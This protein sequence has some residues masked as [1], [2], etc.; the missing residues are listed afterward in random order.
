MPTTTL[1]VY[2]WD[3][4]DEGIETCLDRIKDEL[5]ID[6][7]SVAALYH[8]G[9]FLLPRN[10]KRRVY[11][12]EPGACYFPPSHER[13]RDLAI[14]PIRSWVAEDDAYGRI[15]SAAADRGLEFEAWVLGFHN[16]GIGARHPE[17]CL[18][19]AYGDRYPFALCPAN[20]DARRFIAAVIDDLLAR[21]EPDSVFLET[22]NY[23]NYGHGFH[24]E[25]TPA[26]STDVDKYLLSL[27]FCEHC[28]RAFEDA[29]IETEQVRRWITEY[30]DE[31]LNTYQDPDVWE[32]EDFDGLLRLIDERDD[33]R[34]I[35]AA[36]QDIVADVAREYAEASRSGGSIF[37]IVAGLFARPS[38]RA[39]MEGTDLRAHSQLADEM[40]VLAYHP[41]VEAVVA[42]AS[43]ALSE[44]P[45]DKLRLALMVSL[46]DADSP[47]TLESKVRAVLELGIDNLG[48]YNYGFMNE[49]RLSWLQ[50][51]TRLVRESA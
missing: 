27:C 50:N 40:S 48:F 14:Q 4:I 2:P 45:E 7:V 11:F 43:H 18:E 6:R 10:P 17:V 46:P 32:G 21:Y 38:S 37:A 31:R 30:L 42:D 51:A 25:F 47:E 22:H 5:G 12:P 29:G 19:N 44:I 39:W 23:M 34:A 16:T 1:W 49:P 41:D 28:S 9:K 3:I 24:H 8:S 15:R 35:N 26:P 13:Y 20:P 33:L 36:R